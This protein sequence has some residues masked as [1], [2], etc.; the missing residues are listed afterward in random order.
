[1]TAVLPIPLYPYPPTDG[2][3]SVIRHA[4][5]AL[6]AR[7]ALD[8]KIQIVEAVPG[9]P[10]RVLSAGGR[11]P[12]VCD[13]LEVK[14]GDDIVSALAWALDEKQEHPGAYLKEHYLRDLIGAREIPTERQEEHG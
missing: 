12:F 4:K 10:T 6:A 13:V 2:L 11:P 3:R 8:F 7:E 9:E 14:P 1:M 5:D